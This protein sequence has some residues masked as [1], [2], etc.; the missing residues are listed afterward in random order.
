MK[1]KRVWLIG[2]MA[3]GCVSRAHAMELQG[4]KSEFQDKRTISIP[5]P[6]ITRVAPIV[7]AST[8]ENIY[9]LV[10]PYDPKTTL[11][12]VHADCLMK[13]TPAGLF[14][15]LPKKI[16]QELAS[17]ACRTTDP[18]KIAEMLNWAAA[19][20]GWTTTHER[21][22]SAIT[23]L[24]KKFSTMGLSPYAPNSP[25]GHSF[26]KALATLGYAFNCIKRKVYALENYAGTHTAYLYNNVLS[27]A[28]STAVDVFFRFY[29]SDGRYKKF[30]I[31][32]TSG[33]RIAEYIR[34]AQLR[35]KSVKRS[36]A[37]LKREKKNL[38]NALL[39][40]A[41]QK[42]TRLRRREIRGELEEINE[43]IYGL[44]ASSHFA[45]ILY[46]NQP[47]TE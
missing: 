31:V 25:Q 34:Q 7:R 1:F 18:E 46:Q 35:E 41:A 39:N 11:V 10:E 36:L 28:G 32:D 33:D 45:Y 20:I 27:Y 37:E 38:E 16:Q 6:I 47:I 9:D 2:A 12:V 43:Q 42:S 8:P 29:D 21:F 17:L 14:V 13:P 5:P 3:L 30:I 24:A 4:A 44:R 23:M 40:L 26:F 19:Q 15:N 22:P